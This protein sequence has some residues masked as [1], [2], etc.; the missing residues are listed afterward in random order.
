MCVT[1]LFLLVQTNAFFSR[2][3]FIV[4]SVCV[5]VVFSLFQYKISQVYLFAEILLNLQSFFLY[6]FVHLKL[7]QFSWDFSKWSVWCSHNVDIHTRK[8][9]QNTL[10]LIIIPWLT[11][12]STASNVRRHSRQEF[13]L[14]VRMRARAQSIVLFL[15]GCGFNVPL[16]PKRS[17]SISSDDK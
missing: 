16:L 10:Q 4:L 15:C 14:G 6:F 3:S 9:N 2:I 5:C 7:L 1:R 11:R 17:P 13:V 8:Y 12:T